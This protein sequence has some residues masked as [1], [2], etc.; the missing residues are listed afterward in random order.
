MRRP[1]PAKKH[2]RV[3]VRPGVTPLRG[4]SFYGGNGFEVWYV[5]HYTPKKCYPGS[6][7][8]LVGI[9]AVK[10]HATRYAKLLRDRVKLGKESV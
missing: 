7:S 10:A 8:R 3:D 1:P 5:E 9:F 6:G 4:D 2:R